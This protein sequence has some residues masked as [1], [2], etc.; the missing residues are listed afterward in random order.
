MVR[1][2]P[3]VPERH[4]REGVLIA[5]DVVHEDYDG[6]NLLF[7]VQLI[8]HVE[9]PIALDG[10]ANRPVGRIGEVETGGLLV[11]KESGG[12]H[13]EET[14]WFLEL[15]LPKD[16]ITMTTHLEFNTIDLVATGE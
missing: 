8:P 6:W 12:L 10:I 11:G 1:L 15:G 5:I 14:L 13:L 7:W 9:I 16:T 4:I 3:V 2:E